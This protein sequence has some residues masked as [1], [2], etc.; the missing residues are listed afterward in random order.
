MKKYIIK[1]AVLSLSIAL[2]AIEL[3]SC[4]ESDMKVYDDKPAIFFPKGDARNGVNGVRIDTAH[5]SFFHNPGKEE[6]QVPYKVMLI[7]RVLDE[8]KE[9]SVEVVD[10]LSTAK[11]DEYE[12]PEKIIFR[13]GVVAD[14]LYIKIF[15]KERLSTESTMLVLNIKENE[16]FGLGYSNMLRVKLRFD[17]IASKPGWWDDTIR[18]VYFGEFSIAKYEVFMNISGRIDI[19][20]LEAW[21]L[22]RLCLDM[23]E[24]IK[25]EGITEDDGSPMEIV[26]Y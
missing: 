5:V 25:K 10:S 11:A 8:D 1:T 23:R 19:V 3:T 17:N 15:K 21:E 2:S 22:R 14:S 24:Y 16:N 20:G 18:Y 4:K 7:G 12:L 9:Y 26:G 6:L 13:K